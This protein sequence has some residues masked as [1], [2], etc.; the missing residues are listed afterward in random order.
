MASNGTQAAY[1]PEQVLQA[2]LTMRGSDT[3]RKKTAHKFLE[4]FQKSVGGHASGTVAI[5]MLGS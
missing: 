4:G 1:P 5:Y 2:M 3:E